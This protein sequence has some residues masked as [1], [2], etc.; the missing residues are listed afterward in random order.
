MNGSAQ[1]SEGKC[2]AG[3]GSGKKKRQRRV[4]R[5]WELTKRVLEGLGRRSANE[6]VINKEAAK[7]L[8]LEC[9]RSSFRLFSGLYGE[10][11]SP[12]FTV[13]SKIFT[14]HPLHATPLISG[15]LG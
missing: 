12:V 6:K 4:F 9:L 11:T 13:T 8:G 15:A 7:N 3:Q 5:K 14:N 10:M 1:G 2:G